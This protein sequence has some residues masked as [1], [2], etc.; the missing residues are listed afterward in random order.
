[1]RQESIEKSVIDITNWNR[2]DAYYIFKSFDVPYTNL[3]SD[4]DITNFMRFIRE[5]DYYFFAALLYYMT[6]AANVVK[7]FR[8]RLEGDTPVVWNKIHAN[9][10]LM[11][12]NGVMGN[13]YTEYCD[14]FEVF[15]ENALEDL[16][17]GKKSGIIFNKTFPEGQSNAVVTI[18][19]IPW[20]KISNF[21]Q[22]VYRVGDAVPYIGV[23]RR[24]GL[25]ERLLL[26]IA[27]QAH[28][29]FVD[30]FHMAHYFKLLE[31][32]LSDP[33]KYLDNTISYDFLLAESKPFI[34]SEKEKPINSF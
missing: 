29:A 22:A 1:M 24:Y 9:Y 5:N 6:K 25:G 12:E 14:N 31:L 17:H 27:V 16:N 7:E 10:T 32:M 20:T 28:H 23:G 11:Q 34:L 4:L 30:G 26:P 33:K 15:Y 3:C 21:T 13:S 18:T 2:A 8:Y 19:S